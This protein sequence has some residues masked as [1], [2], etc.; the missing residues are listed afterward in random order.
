MK[1]SALLS[2]SAAIAASAAMVAADVSATETEYVELDYVEATGVQWVD[3]GIIGRC[4]TKAEIKVEWMDLSE[5][6]QMLAC[7]VGDTRINLL[8]AYGAEIG[9]GYGAYNKAVYKGCECKW[10]KD[11]LYT[12]V[13]DFAASGDGASVSMTVDGTVIVDQ[14]ADVQIDTGINLVIFGNNITGVVDRARLSRSR[15]YGLKIWQDGSLVRDFVP[16]SVDGRAGF[17]DSVSG[18]FFY[19]ASGTDLM[20]G[21]LANEPDRFVDYIESSGT[22]YIDLEVKGKSGVKMESRMM[23]VEIPGDGSY[24]ASRLGSSP[25]FYLMHHYGSQTIGYGGYYQSGAVATAGTI[26]DTVTELKAGAQTCVVNGETIYSASDSASI[27]TGLNLYLFGCN[28][29]GGAT[30]KSKAR[31]YSL[32]LWD[33]ENLVRDFRP[34]LKR[35]EACLY[36][37][38]SHRIFRTKAGTLKCGGVLPTPGK[39][40]YF[41]TYIESKGNNYLDTG[42][43]AKNDL[44]IVGD[45]NYTQIRSDS[46]ETYVY[47]EPAS[48]K[49]R[50]FIGACALDGGNRCY[51]VH[52]NAKAL[53]F[54]YGE[55]RVY[56]SAS[57]EAEDTKFYPGTGRH[58]FDVTLANGGQSVNF[59]ETELDLSGDAASYDVDAG[60]NLYLFACNKGGTAQYQSNVRCY[61]LKIWQNGYPVR[62]LRPCVKD[63]V[64][65]FYDSVNDEIIYTVRPV[66]PSCV[67]EMDLTGESFESIKGGRRSVDGDYEVHT[68]TS[69]GTLTVEGR[70]AVD[71]LV[72]GGGGGGGSRLAAGGGGGGGG[73]IYRESFAVTSGVYQVVVGAGGIGGN[74]DWGENGGDSSIFGLV[75]KGG[76]GG[77]GNYPAGTTHYNGNNGGNGGGGAGAGGGG[78]NS[79]GKGES[80]QGNDGGKG[81]QWRGG[82]GGGY[83][84]AGGDSVAK[85]QAGAGGAGFECSIA[86]KA[87]CYGSGG[88]GGSTATAGNGLGGDGAGNGG[89]Y[90]GSTGEAGGNGVDGTGGGGGGSGGN[91]VSTASGRGGNGGSG[92][93]IIRCR[94]IPRGT[95]LVIR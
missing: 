36:D 11:R 94:H 65:G 54:G 24:V 39:P 92:V 46:E 21:T 85:G 9:Y 56:P 84:A 12:V 41:V 44:R 57:P 7:R 86:G 81:Y 61:S 3:T 22:E 40:D 25:R 4:G 23:W 38:V 33:G 10:E 28:K 93:V 88:G 26:Y 1:T 66:D 45:F 67:G 34:C 35:G 18:G 50:T 76:G 82:G 73:V 37:Q 63:G 77:G 43:R 16:V 53:W 48:K 78:Y 91:T 75:A 59:D 68:F 32:K 95:R 47:L 14:S 52:V 27:D 72:V 83:A 5:D 89:V 79:P 62:N 17:R 31:C 87:V 42:V 80:G 70:E 69:S 90:N 2:A 64:A 29:D 55:R 58:T 30:Y 51:A 13:T 8:N 60:C 74:D 6:T 19:S 15:C 20:A 49:E 71:I